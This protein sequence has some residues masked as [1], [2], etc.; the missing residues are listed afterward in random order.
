[1]K[2]RPVVIT[3]DVEAVP[4]F[5][6]C[7]HVEYLIWG[8]FGK[9][10]VGITRMMDIADEHGCKLTFFIDYCEK[11]LYPSA[12]ENVSC[13]IVERGH[14]LQLHAHMDLLPREFW[15]KHSLEKYQIGLSELPQDRAEILF[16]FL[17]DCAVEMGGVTPVAFRGG[18][19][20]FNHEILKVMK[21]KGIDLSFNYNINSLH[22]PNNATNFPMFK[23]SNDVLELPLAITESGGRMQPFEFN[24]FYN[25]GLLTSIRPDRH[26]AV[27]R[28]MEKY[29]RQ[30]ENAVMVMLMHSW[31]FTDVNPQTG[32]R[33][34]RDLKLVNDFESFLANLP[35]QFEIITASDLLNRY[36]EG[37]LN[38]GIT[39]DVELMDREK[40]GAREL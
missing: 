35:E 32:Y 29:F 33:T 14:D 3:I 39:R 9:E 5:E 24:D 38:V 18:N 2:K 31:S 7:N 21:G 13:R 10:I 25:Y 6:L 19:F 1:M 17:I 40:Y 37:S 34:F 12:F 8:R 30:F 11:F 23:W 27:Y 28:F 20:R 4:R 16:D 22:Q 36:R 26:R 15:K